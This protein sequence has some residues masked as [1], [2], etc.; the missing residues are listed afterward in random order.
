LWPSHSAT[1]IAK[2]LQRP[3]WSVFA[4]VHRLRQEGLL[5]GGIT[6]RFAVPPKRTRPQR[7]KPETRIM[8][9]KPARALSG[10]AP[11]LAM[12]P[13]SRIELADGRCHWP[14]GEVQKVATMFCGGSAVPRR[15]YCAHHLR[16]ARGQGSAS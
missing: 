12:Q 8:P 14:L 13:C 16:I 6:K 5:D 2:R 7:A 4:K 11:P 3:H 9:Q 10:Q 15:R 1:Q